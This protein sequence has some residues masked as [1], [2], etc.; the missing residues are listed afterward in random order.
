MNFD[1]KTIVR[2]IIFLMGAIFL[3]TFF[4]NNSNQ[5]NS[6]EKI[7][8]T[9]F[10]EE[11][12]NKKI[13]SVIITEEGRGIKE[14][15]VL[16][17]DNSVYLINAPQDAGLMAD[18]LNSNVEINAVK[19]EE[20]LFW[21]LFISWFPMI[22]FVGIWIYFMRKSMGG[23]G[24]IFSFGK[25]KANMLA[26]DE[27][28][29]KFSDVAGCDEAKEEIM[30]VVEFLKN[31]DKFSR[32]GGKIPRGVLLT[33]PPGT[34]KTML[35][36][37]TANEA[38]VPFF[39]T[40]GSSFVEMFVGVGAA[41]VR[42]M[43]ED[44]KKFAPC[45]LFID[46]IDALGQ[47]RS[48][49]MGQ[50]NDER[51]QTLNQ[52][53]IEMDGIGT[54]N[55]VIIVGATNRP[56]NLDPAILRP[57]RLDRQVVVNLPDV[58]GREQILKIHSKNVLIDVNLNINKIARGTPGFSGADLANLVNEAAIFAAR[59]NKKYVDQKD[60]EMA[61]DKIIMGPE[62]RSMIMPEAEKE[63]T[64]YHESGHAVVAKLLKNADPVHKVTIIPR[65]R[66]LGVT[67]QLPAEDKY[68]H[69]KVYLLDMIAVLMGGRIAEE[70][71]LGHMTTGASNDIERATSIARRMVTEFGMSSL[72]P[73]SY[74]ERASGGF[75]GGGYSNNQFLA[76]E[77]LSKIDAEIRKII[78]D[79]YNVA[80]KI[81]DNN[82]DK[83]EAMAKTLLEIE[84]IDD[85]QITNIMEDKPVD[86]NKEFHL[87]NNKHVE[88]KGG[89]SEVVSGQDLLDSI[90]DKEL[91]KL[92]PK[93]EE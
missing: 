92:E 64:A 83:I 53:L 66:A 22:L 65:G 19:K 86:H 45:I 1:K 78:D 68:S 39:H 67:M 51:E 52:L 89:D 36:K 54:N 33:G 61:K 7:S 58:S 76:P 85:W 77:T 47:R 32:L 29:V 82:K 2:S 42:D 56:D 75:L 60:F 6:G 79:Q 3:V 8:Y 73:V 93:I 14:I 23:K 15:K 71:F 11:I 5:K 35:A 40:S 44:A 91:D 74:G 34:G 28:G 20:S 62:R 57:G 69:D 70:V 72:G 31:P 38:G 84:T 12:K 4:V 10:I 59:S 17:S 41:R 13:K 18:L 49:G 37:A 88:V 25:N 90:N 27:N 43:F 16:R 81:I 50:G 87:K 63:N 26:K 9:K 30:E 21:S 46:E 24:G 55:G 48:G 80:K